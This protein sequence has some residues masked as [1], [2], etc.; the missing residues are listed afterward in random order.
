MFTPLACELSLA[1]G[2]KFKPEYL[3]CKWTFIKDEQRRFSLSLF[4]FTET[5]LPRPPATLFSRNIPW[6]LQYNNTNRT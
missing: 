1:L 2:E 4:C 6:L 5:S 3:N